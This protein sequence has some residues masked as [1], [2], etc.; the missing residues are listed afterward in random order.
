MWLFFSIHFTIHPIPACEMAVKLM[1]V[2]G[3]EWN[4]MELGLAII[5]SV[6]VV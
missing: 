3:M 5:V 4:G 2:N 1:N 6:V